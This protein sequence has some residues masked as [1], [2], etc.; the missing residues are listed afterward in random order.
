MPNPYQA[1]IHAALWPSRQPRWSKI[2]VVLDG[3]RDDRIF[4]AVEACRLDKCCLYAGHLPWVLVRAAPHLVI[5][6]PDDRFTHLILEE[7][8]GNSW[9]IFFRTEV[10]M[11]E[12]RRHLR[13][14]LT[15]KDEQ[16][17]QLLFRWYDPRVLRSYL[18]TCEPAE[19]QTIFGPIDRFYCET[20][21]SAAMLE[22][23]FEG[24][25][26]LQ[27]IHQLGIPKSAG[28]TRL[29]PNA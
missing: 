3:A 9:G 6:E 2:C 19:L 15:V 29:M 1:N 26:L 24:E 12:V 4:S 17:R 8:W 21:D 7:G 20:E 13:S 18:P 28:D 11:M 27:H 16:G 22:Y 14:L 10:P 23:R 5:L 25:S